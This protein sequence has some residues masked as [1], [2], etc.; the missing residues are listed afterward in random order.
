MNH[1]KP[2]GALPSWD[3]CLS[4]W[5]VFLHLPKPKLWG[6]GNASSLAQKLCQAQTLISSLFSALF[7]Q[8]WH[9]I[10]MTDVWARTK[11]AYP[12]PHP[13]K[14]DHLKVYCFSVA[15]GGT[16][17]DAWKRIGILQNSRIYSIQTH[18]SDISVR[19]FIKSWRSHRQGQR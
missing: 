1:P 3:I 5:S 7:S 10:S 6:K 12:V 11:G 16:E 4:V 17:M 13:K 18:V 15:R 19:R 2:H 14:N 8:L 9:K